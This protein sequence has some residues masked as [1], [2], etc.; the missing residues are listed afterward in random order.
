MF[1]NRLLALLNHMIQM[2]HLDIWKLSVFLNQSVKSLESDIHELNDTLE[3]LGF[4]KID[5]KDGEYQ[6]PESLII[7][8]IEIQAKLKNSQIFLQEDERQ[9]L[10]Y[11]YTFIRKENISNYHYQ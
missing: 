3:K 8:K 2:P 9:H 6:V 11:L 1:D 5:I 10:I 4:L 7:Q